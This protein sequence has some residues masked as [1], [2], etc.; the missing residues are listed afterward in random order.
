MPEV[1]FSVDQSKS[2][3]DQAVP[4]EAGGRDVDAELLQGGV[5]EQCGARCL[6]Q[7]YACRA[8]GQSATEQNRACGKDQPG[9][10]PPALRIA[11][12]HGPEPTRSGRFFQSP[13]GG[14]GRG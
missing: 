6:S 4:F 3:R 2:M 7:G 9:P 14:E 13:V 10:D 5:G 8:P 1:L 11:T 12:D